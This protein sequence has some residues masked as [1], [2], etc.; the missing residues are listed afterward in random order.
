MGGQNG[1]VE[2]SNLCL[3]LQQHRR[4]RLERYPGCGR[5]IRVGRVLKRG[6]QL[7]RVASALRHHDTQLCE[8]TRRA[9]IRAVR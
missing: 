6:N 1:C 5:K 4:Q 9:L 8:V 3:D 7:A 2:T